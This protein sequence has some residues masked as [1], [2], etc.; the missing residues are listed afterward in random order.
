M[1]KGLW[2]RRLVP[3]P[4]W[5][6]Q[7][8]DPYGHDRTPAENPNRNSQGALAFQNGYSPPTY[9]EDIAASG[10]PRTGLAEALAQ[11][12]PPNGSMLADVL[13]GGGQPQPSMGMGGPLVS[14]AH[15]I[16]PNAPQPS[17]QDL[18]AQSARDAI[19]RARQNRGAGP[20][21]YNENP[22]WLAQR[23]DLDRLQERAAMDQA[24]MARRSAVSFEEFWRR[25]GRQSDEWTPDQPAYRFTPLPRSRR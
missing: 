3:Q 6:A 25:G 17:Q 10:V 1:P 21:S 14:S 9:G 23:Q 15:D 12:P 11:S 13:A 8:L 2:G 19:M 5:V 20:L 24:E 4:N 16:I 22:R 7:L 18:E